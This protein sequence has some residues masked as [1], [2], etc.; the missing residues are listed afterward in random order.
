MSGTVEDEEGRRQN[1]PAPQLPNERELWP[2]W[3]ARAGSP[4]K[5]LMKPPNAPASM[6]ALAVDGKD[7]TSNGTQLTYSMPMS[8][9]VLC[10]NGELISHT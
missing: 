8:K 6:W 4:T 10:R 2:E 1:L 5:P 9:E 3:T 7:R